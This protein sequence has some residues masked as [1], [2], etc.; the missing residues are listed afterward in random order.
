M[1][2]LKPKI[3]TVKGLSSEDKVKVR[4]T[5]KYSLEQDPNQDSK[6][7]AERCW[8]A[9]ASE[10]YVADHFDGYINHGNEN[11]KDPHTYAYD[12]LCHP[13]FSGLRI[14]VKTHQAASKWISCTT[15]RFGRYPGGTGVNLGP[16]VEFSVSDLIIIFKTEQVSP[17]AV[18]LIPHIAAD[19]TAFALKS[20]LVVKSKFDGWILSERLNHDFG[21]CLFKVFTRQ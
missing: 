3:F 8:I 18:R 4:D 17:G 15:G 21:D 19:R 20:G 16:F 13:R 9:V 1:L 5:I 11:L 6:D 7:V 2:R 14:E 12:V 10:R